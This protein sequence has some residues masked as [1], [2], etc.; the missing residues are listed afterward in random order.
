MV[1]NQAKPASNPTQ[2]PNVG[3]SHLRAINLLSS[4][5]VIRLVS[6]SDHL[7]VISPRRSGWCHDNGSKRLQQTG[8]S[9]REI[10]SAQGTTLSRSDCIMQ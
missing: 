4:S 3:L 2:T 8:L 7:L 9:W 6:V 10:F 1:P 5:E